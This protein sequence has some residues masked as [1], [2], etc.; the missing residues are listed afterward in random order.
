LLS[1]LDY[2]E[3][4]FLEV[5]VIVT[6]TN[7][8][9]S[10]LD[11]RV[12]A[13][14]I[15]LMS[16]I[17]KEI[18][19]SDLI[20]LAGGGCFNEYSEWDSN[21]LEYGRPDYNVMC[22]LVSQVA[23]SLNRRVFICGVGIEPLKSFDARISV[24]RGLLY[25][26]V[27]TLRDVE[28][29]DSLERSNLNS[30]EVLITA[31]PALSLD[32]ISETNSTQSREGILVGVS[33]RFWNFENL[34]ELNVYPDWERKVAEDLRQIAD[35]YDCEFVFIPFQSENGN[36]ELSNDLPIIYRVI[37]MAGIET[38]SSIVDDSNPK[39]V[40][41][42]ISKCNLMIVCRYHSAIF[43]IV[44]TVPFVTLSYSQKVTSAARMA[45]LSDYV[46][47]LS[48]IEAG[49]LSKRVSE[50]LSNLD[51]VRIKLETSSKSIKLS[52]RQN[53]S[54]ISDL[55]NSDV[56]ED[57]NTVKY[58]FNSLLHLFLRNE[59]A[60]KLTENRE[61]LVKNLVSRIEDSSTSGEIYKLISSLPSEIRNSP[62]VKYLF[63]L[64]AH[65][66][67]LP[68][69][70][71]KSMYLD[72]AGAGASKFWVLYNLGFLEFQNE[73][74]FK[75][76]RTWRKAFQVEPNFIEE[77]GGVQ[78]ELKRV[79]SGPVLWLFLKLF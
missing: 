8:E 2:I 9:R 1:L 59:S 62:Q 21:S 52:S 29:L 51:Q 41:R 38:K 11:V 26:D 25:A 16:E 20:I 77:K 43:A 45:N 48:R 67:G 27:V 36:S 72:S 14:D 66:S 74:C 35:Q 24:A 18:Y 33:L 37:E 28:S 47:D 42:Q 76:I 44:A 68:Y 53:F 73:K 78:N 10:E 39:D 60:L 17:L 15:E 64:A 5:E 79:F 75:A 46:I 13:I 69:L 31:C 55:L 58:V 50:I 22:A 32:F 7:I 23:Y 19:T 6:S 34:F 49:Q 56:K 30:K 40:L 61:N 54:I 12:R 71:T 65:T 3:E 57:Q 70:E 4:H 63:A